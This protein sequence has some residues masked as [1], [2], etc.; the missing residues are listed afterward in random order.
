MKTSYLKIEE[1]VCKG[2]GTANAPLASSNPVPNAFA[3]K[4]LDAPSSFSFG[5]GANTKSTSGF[6]SSTFGSPSVQLQGLEEVHRP[7]AN[8]AALLRDLAVKDSWRFGH[9]HFR[10]KYH[11]CKGT[12]R[13]RHGRV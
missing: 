5:A 7:T 4:P 10:F 2:L 9:F 1:K 6:A 12:G 11:G 8:L 3:S 13:S